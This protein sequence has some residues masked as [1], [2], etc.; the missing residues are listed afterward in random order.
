[1]FFLRTQSESSNLQLFSRTTEADRVNDN[2]RR[3]FFGS[4]GSFALVPMMGISASESAQSE[5]AGP[6][7]GNG[8]AMVK[9]DSVACPSWPLQSLGAAI[10][11]G[12]PEAGG[13][14]V[15][16]SKDHQITSGVWT[17]SP[18]SFDLTFTWDEM[19]LLLEGELIIEEASGKKFRLLPGDFFSVPR[20]VKTRWVVVKAM[21]KL[22]FSRERA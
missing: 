2:S 22:F 1:M 13:K 9:L 19:A 6:T 3:G 8:V 16:E 5:A 18:G 10:V 4:L 11:Q 17:C 14:T 20:G 15:F 21:K 12:H 7:E